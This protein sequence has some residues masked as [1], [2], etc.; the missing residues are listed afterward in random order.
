[1]LPAPS[2]LWVKWSLQRFAPATEC[3]CRNQCHSSRL[4]SKIFLRQ[5]ML[6]AFNG[7][8]IELQSCRRP[9]F[10][11][12]AGKIRIGTIFEVFDIGDANV[13]L[14]RLS[15]G[16]IKGAAVLQMKERETL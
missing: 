8:C 14:E 4:L 9:R 13:A 2:R 3:Q 12:L 10:L 11:S 5:L 6:G 1:M 16:T 7:E 15:Q